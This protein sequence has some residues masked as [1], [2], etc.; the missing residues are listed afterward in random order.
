MEIYSVMWL[1]GF[2]FWGRFIDRHTL[3]NS[4]RLFFAIT[5]IIPFIYLTTYNIWF[6]AIAQA[7]AGITFAAIELI[8]YIVITRMSEHKETPRYMAVYVV[9]GGIRG[10]T[11][12]FLGTMLMKN[13]SAETAIAVSLMFIAAAFISAHFAKEV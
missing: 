7:V 12:P 6:L 2:F 1:A 9:F 3:S 11:A 8:G 4:L 5:A 10:A 13:F